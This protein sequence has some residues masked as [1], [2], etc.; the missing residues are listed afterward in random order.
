MRQRLLLDVPHCYYVPFNCYVSVSHAGESITVPAWT[1]PHASLLY[2]CCRWSIIG[3]R[4]ILSCVL[5]VVF[6]LINQCQCF[7]LLVKFIKHNQK[8][9]PKTCF[10][11]LISSGSLHDGQMPLCQKSGRVRDSVGSCPH[12]G[13]WPVVLP[14]GCVWPLRSI[15]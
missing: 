9:L 4:A 13:S 1:R 10:F 8:L 5:F 12:H 11:N 14:F 7:S 3:P 6:C 15:W 2:R